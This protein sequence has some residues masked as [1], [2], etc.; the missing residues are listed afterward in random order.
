MELAQA[1][2]AARDALRRATASARRSTRSG[3]SVLRWRQGAALAVLVGAVAALV[4]LVMLPFGGTGAVPLVG[5]LLAVAGL[6]TLILLAPGRRR[7]AAP[8]A[9]ANTSAP[10]S[11][12]RSVTAQAWAGAPVMLIGFT[13][14]KSS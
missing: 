1:E 14:L 7:A 8:A 9:R 6:G 4:G 10:I 3:P 12:F 13:G 11:G 5:L 2:K